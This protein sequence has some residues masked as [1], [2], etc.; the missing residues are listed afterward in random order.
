MS[1][2]PNS[3]GQMLFTSLLLAQT[4][5]NASYIRV[6]SIVLNLTGRGQ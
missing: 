6:K 2:F 3:A 1:L 4:D 5:E